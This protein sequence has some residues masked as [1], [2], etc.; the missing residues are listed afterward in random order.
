MFPSP[1]RLFPGA[2][3]LPWSAM[4][5]VSSVRAEEAEELLTQS[6]FWYSFFLKK[7]LIQILPMPVYLCVL[8]F[9]Y[10]F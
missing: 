8:N 6:Y 10:T 1:N 3:G 7:K 5:E 9:C 2:Q 4:L